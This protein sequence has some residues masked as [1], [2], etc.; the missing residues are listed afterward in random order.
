M[1]LP[2]LLSYSKRTSQDMRTCAP[3]KKRFLD[4]PGTHRK[5]GDNTFCAAAPSHWNSLPL[6][7]RLFHLSPFLRSVLKLT[8]FHLSNLVSI[9]GFKVFLM[10]YTFCWCL[11]SMHVRCRLLS[12]VVLFSDY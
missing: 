2:T 1:H 12:V 5:C 7:I 6:H 4:V 8:F 10:I 11:F 9:P 3:Q